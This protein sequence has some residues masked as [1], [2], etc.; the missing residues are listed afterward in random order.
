M[1]KAREVVKTMIGKMME[2]EACSSREGTSPF[3][4]CVS[5]GEQK[6]T[7]SQC[8]STTARDSF[9]SSRRQNKKNNHAAQSETQNNN[10]REPSVG[11]LSEAKFHHLY[12]GHSLLQRGTLEPLSISESESPRSSTFH[13]NQPNKNAKKP[14]HIEYFEELSCLNHEKE[15]RRRR[16]PSPDVMSIGNI[17]DL[18]REF[19]SNSSIHRQGR[20]RNSSIV[21][22][23]E[24]SVNADMQ[25]YSYTSLVP[26]NTHSTETPREKAAKEYT[27]LKV[28]RR[29]LDYDFRNS[30]SYS[31]TTPRRDDELMHD[32]ERC[33][34]TFNEDSMSLLGCEISDTTCNAGCQY[35]SSRLNDDKA[36]DIDL[37]L[38]GMS[39]K[40]LRERMK[41]IDL[42]HRISVQRG[43][44]D[45]HSDS[46]ATMATRLL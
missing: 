21:E 18:E 26:I 29:Q 1:E 2:M 43:K 5:V 45:K 3:N 10:E 40:N 46:D 13:N 9:S 4:S 22:S 36:L 42:E 15:Y 23:L 34:S 16:N 31:K 20:Q 19:H 35:D 17:R 38:D 25:N 11:D 8:P 27:A 14:S 28:L 39:L 32:V 37:S 6:P 7:S 44:V 30:L 33:E 41:K 12:N 24:I